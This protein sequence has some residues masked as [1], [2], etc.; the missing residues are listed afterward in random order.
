MKSA[1]VV[2]M[3]T[4]DFAV[5]SLEAM[6]SAGWRPSVVVTGVDKP[7]GRGQKWSP[8]PVKACALEHE[9]PVWEVE[10]V[11]DEAFADR[12]RNHAPDLLVVVAFRILP[13]AVYET[14]RLGAF[15]L[16]GSLLPA[17]R[18]AAP[19]HHAVLNGEQETGVTTFLLQR[20]VDA[21][22]IL[23]QA[24]LSIGA[25]ETTGTVYS[26]MMHLGG[27]VVVDTL[28]GLAKG[29][30]NPVPQDAARATP[31]PK[32]FKSDGKLRPDESA[33]Q[34][35]NRIRAMT[36]W[37]GAWFTHQGTVVKINTAQVPSSDLQGTTQEPLY[38]ATPGTV[39]VQQGRL[40]YH[41]ADG[42]VELTQVTPA[43]KRP[44]PGGSFPL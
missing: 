12:L 17:Y 29:S 37:P 25:N 2:F 40:W 8:T 24:P 1:N 32:V 5:A 30:L 26:R 9:I 42:P 23:L 7:R 35:Y 6:V 14:A 18:G 31:A 19:I 43:G 28:E 39:T 27:Q 38:Q 41:A 33:I 13:P 34:T 4:P 16:H 11:R 22:E 36:P 21:G 10:D 44:M 15:N 20:E 3:G